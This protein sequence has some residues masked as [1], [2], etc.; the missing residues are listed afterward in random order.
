MSKT[1]F[2]M[3]QDPLPIGYRVKVSTYL[4]L[5]KW[6]KI[7]M[8]PKQIIAYPKAKNAKQAHPGSIIF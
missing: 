6:K 3:I 8:K 5:P 7:K 4:E 2:Q 1:T